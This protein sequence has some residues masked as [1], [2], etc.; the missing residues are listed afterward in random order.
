MPLPNGVVLLLPVAVPLGEEVV[1]GAIDDVIT[2]LLDV[3]T[4]TEALPEFVEAAFVELGPDVAAAEL[5]ALEE[6]PSTLVET[7]LCV[8]AVDPDAGEEVGMWPTKYWM[9]CPVL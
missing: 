5:G 8:G 4:V 7:E 1:E 9:L 6:L 2:L 3:N